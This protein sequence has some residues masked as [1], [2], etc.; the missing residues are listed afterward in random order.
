MND[1]IEFTIK[2]LNYISK[3]TSM[4]QKSVEEAMNQVK[5]IIMKLHA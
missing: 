5:T 3:A 2:G 4:E 1:F